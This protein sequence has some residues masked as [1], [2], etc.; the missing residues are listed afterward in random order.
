MNFFGDGHLV[1][2]DRHNPNLTFSYRIDQLAL[3]LPKPHALA[4][5]HSERLI[6]LL[7]SLVSQRSLGNFT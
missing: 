3:L 1:D 4:C 2:F 6:H 7:Q 5:L